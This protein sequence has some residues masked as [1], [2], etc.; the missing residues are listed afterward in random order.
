MSKSYRKQSTDRENEENIDRKNIISSIIIYYNPT[1]L[2][3]NKIRTVP[4]QLFL[5]Q[6][7]THTKRTSFGLKKI[8]NKRIYCLKPLVTNH[9]I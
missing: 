9:C 1:H 2:H 8:Y 6:T 4:L 7:C 5:I 3:R